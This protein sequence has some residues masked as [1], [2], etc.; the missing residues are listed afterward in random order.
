MGK[1]SRTNPSNP[2]DLSGFLKDL[3]ARLDKAIAALPKSMPKSSH[4]PG[5]PGAVG[6]RVI[7]ATDWVDDMITGVR[8]K[9]EKWKKRSL[10]PKKDPIK[11][12]IAAN[13]K[14]IDRLM[15][16]IEEKW[17]E[18]KMGRLT[19]DDYFTGV[20]AT[21]PGDYVKGVERKRTKI[22]KRISALQPLVEAL[23]KS[24]DAM[25]QETDEQR[26]ARMLAARKG[27]IEIGKKLKGVI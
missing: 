3:S 13:P 26:E 6:P 11:A 23:A 25:P 5:N 17:W 7:S 15:K 19:I 27:M 24:I 14:R 21:E 8:A 22:E 12:A 1:K 16:S 18:K 10:A 2:Y 9:R 4:N 20:E